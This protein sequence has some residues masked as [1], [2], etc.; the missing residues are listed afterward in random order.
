MLVLGCLDWPW[1]HHFHS[2]VTLSSCLL[3]PLWLGS[4]SHWE[5]YMRG[6]LVI[7]PWERRLS[8]HP[9]QT[10]SDGSRYSSYS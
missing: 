8:Q 10:V 9:L 3:S 2:C 6:S 1:R 7:M 4:G 5:P